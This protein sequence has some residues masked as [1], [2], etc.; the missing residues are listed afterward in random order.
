[1]MKTMNLIIFH[2]VIIMICL[3]ISLQQT[4]NFK[5]PSVAALILLREVYV[6]KVKYKHNL[7]RRSRIQ[8]SVF[9]FLV[10]IHYR[11]LPP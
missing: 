11:D 7:A 2:Y 4:I 5:L 9:Y 10:V 6:K 1:M 8:E 3:L